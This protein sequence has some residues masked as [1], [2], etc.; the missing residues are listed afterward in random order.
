MTRTRAWSRLNYLDPRK[1]LLGLNTIAATYPLEEYAKPARDLRT[2][3]LRPYGE[4]R[5]C[6]IFCFGMGEIF[7]LNIAYAHGEASDYDF[8][9][10]YLIQGERVFVP[11]QMK[12]F[13]PSELD[14]NA[15]LNKEI[16]KLSKYA[17]SR[18][19]C[20]AIHLNRAGR[21]DFD[22]IRIPELN[23]GELWLFGATSPDLDRWLLVGNMLKD[24]RI[25]EFQYP[26]A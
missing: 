15:D 16:K 26:R 1:I 18:D 2:H 7:G 22:S 24:H 23:I 20:V 11:I 4:S 5:Q 19:L 14:P 9:G 21:L 6:A 10:T 17:D 13:V 3:E 12:E 8:V 25:Y